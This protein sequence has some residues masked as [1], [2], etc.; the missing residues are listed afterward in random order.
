MR[1]PNCGA[2]IENDARLCAACGTALATSASGFSVPP[3]GLVYLF[4]ERFVE[5]ARMMGETLLVS[6]V[7]VKQR[8]LAQSCYLAAFLAL[9]REGA[10]QLRMGK[11]KRGLGLFKANTV[12]AS[13]LRDQTAFP[14]LEAELL[15]VTVEAGRET[16]VG[17]LIWQQLRS[18]TP[19]PWQMA[20]A[21]V[22]EELVDVGCIEA[23]RDTRGGLGR[24]LGDK[25]S[26]IP[27]REKIESLTGEAREVEAMIAACRTGRPDLY[28]QLQKDIARGIASRTEAEDADS[29]WD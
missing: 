15:R 22:K 28:S 21:G 13:A 5:P 17:H 2:T 7:K 4:G 24:M 9:E 12:E 8:E 23:Q 27:V 29:G 1:C 25:V 6:G 11:R 19:S 26:M 20:I 14:A 18:D 10:I 3:S 16:D